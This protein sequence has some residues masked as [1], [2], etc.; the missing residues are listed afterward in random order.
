MQL[1]LSNFVNARGSTVV[2]DASDPFNDVA[3]VS[4]DASGLS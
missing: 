1:Y 3:G 2:A 4:L